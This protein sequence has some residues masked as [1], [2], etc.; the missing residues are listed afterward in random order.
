M[1]S[2]TTAAC[3]GENGQPGSWHTLDAHDYEHSDSVS[4]C[5][6]DNLCETDVGVKTS[7]AVPVQRH[8]GLREAQMHA[9]RAFTGRFERTAL[10]NEG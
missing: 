3:F 4:D 9:A 7:R 6:D 5:H 10:S 8:L 1:C 2:G